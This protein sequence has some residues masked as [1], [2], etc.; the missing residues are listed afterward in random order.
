M[1]FMAKTPQG[2]PDEKTEF[3]KRLNDLCD[4][5]RIP[6]KGKNRQAIVG[7]IFGVSQKAA[8]NW[9]EGEGLPHGDRIIRMAKHFGASIEWLWTGRGPKYLSVA[10]EPTV[11]EA[12]DRLL[13]D[14]WRPPARSEVK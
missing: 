11:Y 10:Y 6:P 2:R 5:A 14:G 3:A 9:L 13:K 1:L 8:R 4:A 7:K 12:A